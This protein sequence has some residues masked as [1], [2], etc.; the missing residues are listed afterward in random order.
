MYLKFYDVSAGTGAAG[1]MG[2]IIG[3]RL[4]CWASWRLSKVMV[5]RITSLDWREG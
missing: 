4:A 5:V 3:L 2:K 1:F